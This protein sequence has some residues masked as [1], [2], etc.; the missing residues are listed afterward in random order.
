MGRAL[1]ARGGDDAQQVH[2]NIL[3]FAGRLQPR[4]LGVMLV[5]DMH[6]SVGQELFAVPAFKEWA[7]TVADVMLY[8]G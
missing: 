2:G 5:S 3:R 8:H 1:R 4:E 7:N 6:R